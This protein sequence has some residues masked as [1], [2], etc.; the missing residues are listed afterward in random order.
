MV[1]LAYRQGFTV[2]MVTGSQYAC[3]A[4]MLWLAALWVPRPRLAAGQWGRLLV[5]GTPMGLTGIFYNNSL[6]HIPASIAIILLL[7]FTWISSLLHFLLERRPP[8]AK[9]LAAIGVILLGSAFAGGVFQSDAA[10]SWRGLLWGLLAAVSFASFVYISSRS[11]GGLHPVYRS[12]IM[13]SGAMLC[14]F[15][16]MPPLSLFTGAA[17]GLL[18]YGLATGLFA[19]LIPP[20]LFAIGMPVVKDLGGILS[21]SELPTA[22]LMAALVLGEPVSGGQWAGVA[23]ILAGIALPSL[24]W[25]R[26][27][28]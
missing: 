7:Q 22:V 14:V 27:R 17:A 10:L 18:P 28:T 6:E 5:S 23:L 1:K 3:G 4:A 2:D 13:T 24:R 9:N 11:S 25:Q 8:A 15:A 20:V 21:A 16:A 12:A 19:S 26:S